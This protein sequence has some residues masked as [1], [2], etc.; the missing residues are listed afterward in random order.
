VG[1]VVEFP[2]PWPG[3]PDTPERCLHS[4][5]G[6]IA[7]YADAPKA[8]AIRILFTAA[9]R[10]KCTGFTVEFAAGRLEEL[11]SAIRAEGAQTLGEA[12]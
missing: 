5:Q 2:D 8:H 1:E 3:A 6:Q 11:A 9:A 7:G 10:L 4:L 12:E